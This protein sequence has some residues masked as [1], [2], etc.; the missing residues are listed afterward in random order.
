MTLLM[1]SGADTDWTEPDGSI[2][3]RATI[4]AWCALSYEQLRSQ[5]E[6]DHAFCEI[7][8]YNYEYPLYASQ[9]EIDKYKSY[10]SFW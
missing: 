6:F 3:N 5:S 7:F 1:D 10:K 8:W 9:S 4:S 2:V